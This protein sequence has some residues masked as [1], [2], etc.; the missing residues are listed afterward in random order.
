VYGGHHGLALVD[1]RPATLLEKG[2]GRYR[3][4]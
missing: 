4:V 1:R 3:H 2:M